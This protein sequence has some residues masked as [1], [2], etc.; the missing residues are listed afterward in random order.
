MIEIKFSNTLSIWKTSFDNSNK[1]QALKE[2]FKLIENNP[3]MN[4]ERDLYTY[5]I[6]PKLNKEAHENFYPISELDR[7]M[8]EGID[9]TLSLVNKDYDIIQSNI[10]INRVKKKNPIQPAYVRDFI[11]HNHVNT[12][13][14]DGLPAPL[15]TFVS[16]IQMP[17]N[18]QED[19]GI[20]I[21]KDIDDQTYSILPQEGETV[22]FPGFVP[23]GVNPSSNSSVDRIVLAGSIGVEK[24]KLI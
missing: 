5:V 4:P 15:Y 7:I 2:S 1:D 13:A 10:W 18:L 22:I 8:K 12:N 14:G 3:N 24:N 16:Y 21:L 6:N 19:E 23:H 17:D 11:F 9:S 20:L